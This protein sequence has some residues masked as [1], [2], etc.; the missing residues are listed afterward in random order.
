MLD[1]DLTEDCDWAERVEEA[2]TLLSKEGRVEVDVEPG[3]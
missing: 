3:A 1:V 2:E